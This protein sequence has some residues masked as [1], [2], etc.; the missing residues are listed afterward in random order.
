VLT[1]A[2][3]LTAGTSYR[4]I[5][6]AGLKDLNERQAAPFQVDITAG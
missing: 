3:G 1:A 4:L 2:S 5:V 6:G